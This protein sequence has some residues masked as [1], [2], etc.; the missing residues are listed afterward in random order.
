MT[1]VYDAAYLTTLDLSRTEIGNEMS[2]KLLKAP[3]M[4]ELY[5]G[6]VAELEERA[7]R[8]LRAIS[9]VPIQVSLLLEED[10]QISSMHTTVADAPEPSFLIGPETTQK[11]SRTD[12][13]KTSKMD[14]I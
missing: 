4:L 7:N 12:S 10:S 14:I 9:D 5:I 3:S 8:V 6:I 11:R 13:W 1:D 2:L